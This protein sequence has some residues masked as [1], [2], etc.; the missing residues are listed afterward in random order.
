[1]HEHKA[2]YQGQTAVPGCLTNAVCLH[3]ALVGHAVSPETLVGI[4]TRETVLHPVVSRSGDHQQDITHNSTEQAP[5]HET[6]HLELRGRGRN[7]ETCHARRGGENVSQLR[8][9]TQGDE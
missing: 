9:P 7:R 3:V 1:M 6:V 2:N 5:S 4:V 8:A